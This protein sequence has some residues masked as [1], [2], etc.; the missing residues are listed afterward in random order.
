MVAAH[1]G[2]RLAVAAVPVYGAPRRP[3]F[4]VHVHGVA[5]WVR[6]GLGVGLGFEPGLRLGLGLGLGMELGLV[7]R[8]R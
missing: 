3:L 8:V 6:L 5:W 4:R 1:V 2:Q 7:L